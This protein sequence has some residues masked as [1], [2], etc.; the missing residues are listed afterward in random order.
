MCLPKWFNKT[1]R[2]KV[3]LIKEHLRRRDGCRLGP[4]DAFI[5]ICNLTSVN[6]ALSGNKLNF[7]LFPLYAFC[8]SRWPGNGIKVLHFYFYPQKTKMGVKLQPP[9]ELFLNDSFLH[10]FP[11]A[12]CGGKT[13]EVSGD[14]RCFRHL[15]WSST[16]RRIH[17]DNGST[18]E[19][20]SPSLT[21]LLERSYI[22]VQL[23]FW[24]MM[25]IFSYWS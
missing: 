5:E 18:S 25:S 10:L 1:A 22:N 21:A 4:G 24:N 17:N 13:F 23:Q 9:L 12:E 15:L 19:A 20:L 2:I 8:G 7:V 14:W 16:S 3:K 11:C 6:N